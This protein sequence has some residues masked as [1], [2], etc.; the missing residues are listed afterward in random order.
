MATNPL[1]NFWRLLQVS[2]SRY[3]HMCLNDD[4]YVPFPFSNA[5][6][7]ELATHDNP[8]SGTLITFAQFFVVSLLGLRK[9][10]VPAR[11]KLSRDV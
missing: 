7:L 8:H 9:Q 3:S 11:P 4:A 6:A 10:F 2:A 1:T 5:W